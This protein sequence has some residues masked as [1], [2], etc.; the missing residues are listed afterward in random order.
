MRGYRLYNPWSGEHLYTADAAEL[1]RLTAS[2]WS[3]EGVAIRSAV[4]GTA[5]YRLYNPWLTAGT[6]LYTRDAAERD[7]LVSLGWRCEGAALRG[8]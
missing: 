6:H 4:S 8:L 7:L 3:Y 1:S 5:V 2:G